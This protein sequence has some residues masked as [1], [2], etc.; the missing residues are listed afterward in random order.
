M[1][2]KPA[3]TSLLSTLTTQETPVHIRLKNADFLSLKPSKTS[4]K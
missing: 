2:R 3:K 4:Q 1:N